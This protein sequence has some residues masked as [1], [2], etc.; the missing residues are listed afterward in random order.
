MSEKLLPTEVTV[1]VEPFEVIE[2]DMQI[3]N[4]F[5]NPLSP[6]MLFMAADVREALSEGRRFW[7]RG[8]ME[9][10]QDGFA[11]CTAYGHGEAVYE[12]FPARFEDRPYKP[13]VYVGR[14]P[15]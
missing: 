1:R 2:W 14:W 7:R 5:D 3:G 13:V 4:P 10:T 8:E 12:L 15:D 11:H 6:V 9:V